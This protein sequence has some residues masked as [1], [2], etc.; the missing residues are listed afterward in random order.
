MVEKVENS[1]FLRQQSLRT[2]KV[3]LNLRWRN[4]C[5]SETVSYKMKFL[6]QKDILGIG[7]NIMPPFTN[8]PSNQKGLESLVAIAI[9]AKILI[10]VTAL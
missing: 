4:G 5:H 1:D 8:N 2:K 3:I 7:Q 6:L 10:E 9:P